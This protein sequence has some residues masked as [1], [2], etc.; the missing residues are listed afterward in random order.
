V[1][2]AAVGFTLRAVRGPAWLAFNLDP[3][4]AYLFNSLLILKGFVPFM[5]EH[6]GVPLEMLGAVVMR[7]LFVATGH[8]AIDADMIARPEAYITAIH[9]A[10]LTL[11]A[12]LVFVTGVILMRRTSMSCT[13]FVQMA[14]LASVPLLA[15]LAVVRPEVLLVGTTVALAGAVV[16]YIEAPE[17]HARFAVQSGI[18]IGVSLALKFTALPWL[19]GPLLLLPT[20][21]TR[22][23]FA[24]AAAAAFLG[25]VIVALRKLP[26]MA[27]WTLGL[28]LQSVDYSGGPAAV[29]TQP[30][31]LPSLV[32]LLGG[33]PIIAI[34]MAA[35]LVTW[36]VWRR[37]PQASER[38]ACR[39]LGAMCAIQIAQFLMVAKHPQAH[40]LVPAIST[41]G[42][43]L[44][45]MTQFWRPRLPR[46]A[47]TAAAVLALAAIALQSTSLRAQARGLESDRRQEEAMAATAEATARARNCV[48]I[49]RYTASAPAYALQFGN[50]WSRWSGL[51]VGKALAARYPAVLFDKGDLEI[52]TFDWEPVDLPALLH[53]RPCVLMEGTDDSLPAASRADF[54]TTVLA[55]SGQESLRQLH[56]R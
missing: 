45:A 10:S 46:G 34:V 35:G 43:S 29:T 9:A 42:V 48:T 55:I 7:T 38:I 6:P 27:R 44:C 33:E 17:R 41:I 18:L 53:D 32:S 3:D 4:Y 37:A 28:A 20:W 47:Q 39:A 24:G 51:R 25:G 2:L 22:R 21:R 8:G 30:R 54:E 50:L 15:E 1:V 11:S 31:L 23:V 36:F 26:Y 19:I 49:Y 52:R 12:L 5:V 16:L 14:P 56:G 13:L 40:Y